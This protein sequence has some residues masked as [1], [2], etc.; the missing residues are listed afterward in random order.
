MERTLILIK[1]DGVRRRLIGEIIHRIEQKSLDIEKLQMMTLTKEVCRE[2][3]KEHEGKDFFPY[4]IRFMTSGPSVAMI[5]KGE[6]AIQEMRMMIG[7]TNPLEA[8]PGSIRGDYGM[9]TS[10]NVVHG[11]DSSES[12]QR[13]IGLFFPEK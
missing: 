10:E 13:E 3:Y 1:P 9:K 7:C 4:L 8:A 6:S 2:H 5:V 11:S 12:A